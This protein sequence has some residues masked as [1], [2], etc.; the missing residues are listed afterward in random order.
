MYNQEK[1]NKLMKDIDSI[2]RRL[3]ELLD[4]KPPT[5]VDYYLAKWVSYNDRRLNLL[6]E[7]VRVL[8][9]KK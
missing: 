9:E 1:L 8:M 3:D 6:I 5:T 7:I 2:G 4:N